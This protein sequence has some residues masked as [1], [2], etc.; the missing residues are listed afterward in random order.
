MK[1]KQILTLGLATALILPL[2]GLTQR[3]WAAGDRDIN[4]IDQQLRENIEE[5]KTKGIT[6]IVNEE[7]VDITNYTN[8]ERTRVEAH[9]NGNIGDDEFATLTALYNYNQ[10]VEKGTTPQECAEGKEVSV[11]LYKIVDN[12]SAGSGSSDSSGSSS[13]EDKDFNRVV[14]G[15]SF[16]VGEEDK[17]GSSTP[18]GS[19]STGTTSPTTPDSSGNTATA[20]TST[21]N[22]PATGDSSSNPPA[23]PATTDPDSSTSAPSAPDSNSANDKTDSDSDAGSS[24]ES[25]AQPPVDEKHDHSTTPNH[26]EDLPVTPSPKPNPPT[27][28]P[29]KVT[30]FND[31][32]NYPFKQQI[33]WLAEQGITR[34]YSDG[35]FHPHE[36]VSREAMAAFLYRMSGQPAYVAPKSSPFNDVAP[37]SA[38]YKE[39]CWLASTGITTGYGD[40]SFRPHAPINRDAMAAFLKRYNDNVAT[41][42][43]PLKHPVPTPFTDIQGNIFSSHIQWLAQSGITT[44]YADGSYRP[45]QA[46]ERGAIATFFYRMKVS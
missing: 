40:G 6:V 12:K 18:G 3:A 9:L 41:T 15:G 14:S 29:T 33:E 10:C 27:T 22:P 30:R 36:S 1:I 26:R 25:P 8:D 17:N 13:E 46:I 39:I 45:L 32:A 34:G 38:F 11:R 42:K 2:G 24:P 44:G 21:S 5:L 23:P 16:I 19:N 7:V 35:G 4:L 20:G 28:P 43:I 31:I 37:G